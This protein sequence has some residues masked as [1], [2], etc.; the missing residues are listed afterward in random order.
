MGD[1]L[2]SSFADDT[3]LVSAI[4][5]SE[6]ATNFQSSLNLV[7]QW[8]KEYNM[9]FNGSKFQVLRIGQND[10][11]KSNTRYLDCDARV[12]NDS[13]IAK[14]LGVIMSSDGSFIPH[15][16]TLV[17]RAFKMSG[18][19][20]RTFYSRDRTTMLTLYKSLVLSLLDYCSPLW[21]PNGSAEMCKK[22]ENVQRAFTR[23]ICDVNHLNYWQRLNELRLYSVQRR[24]E[25]YIIIYMFKIIHGLV[26]NCGISFTTNPRTGIHVKV[27]KIATNLCSFIKNLRQ[28]SF[29]CVGPTLYNLL[30]SDLRNIYTCQNIVFV[31]KQ[32]LDK[33]LSTVPDQPTISGLSRAAK[34]N[35][36]V[37][38]LMSYHV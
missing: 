17:N 21:N 3:K 31:F 5:S 6:D 28:N 23:K 30:P 19:V 34:S 38:Q 29:N 11:I 13:L 24:R 12:I 18:W 4:K 14:D 37:H 35:S 8:A 9:Q 10:E 33:F 32:H 25:R 15:I 2:V 22:V 27:P 20:L 7:Y 16:Q 36:L 1:C 26:P